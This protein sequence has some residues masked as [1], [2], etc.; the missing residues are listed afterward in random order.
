MSSKRLAFSLP[1]SGFYTE[2]ELH[3][4]FKLNVGEADG[5]AVGGEQL[6]RYNHECGRGDEGEPGRIRYPL[7]KL[8]DRK[9]CLSKES[10]PF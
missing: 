10:C 1:F 8:V 2:L 7:N 6:Q 4:E 9:H 3:F 5:C